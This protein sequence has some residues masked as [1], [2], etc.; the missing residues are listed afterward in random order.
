MSDTSQ[1]P[2]WWQASDGKWYPPHLYPPPPA[3]PPPAGPPPGPP[4][5]PPVTAP[6]TSGGLAIAAFV[7]GLLGVVAGLSIIGFFIALPL[8]VC[9]VVFGLI[10]RSR[11]RQGASPRNGLATAG[12]V[13]GAI[14][15]GLGLLGVAII[16]SVFDHAHK[17]LTVNPGDFQVNIDSCTAELGTLK[18]AGTIHNTTGTKKVLVTVDVQFY[19]KDGDVL[20]TGSDFVGEVDSGT[21]S[22][23]SVTGHAL[24]AVGLTCRASVH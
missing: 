20:G 4:G 3:P 10:V 17:S 12:T 23:F 2:G 15:V 6:S 11:V 1:G 14:G 5:A 22:A 8:G 16:G 9:G 18:A 21:T 24:A 13:L 19:A 7:C